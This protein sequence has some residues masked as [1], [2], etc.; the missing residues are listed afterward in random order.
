M[1]NYLK[2]IGPGTLVAAAF[3]GPGTVTVCT[4]AG[5]KFGY[6]LLWVMVFSIFATIVLQ[7]M[8]SR[9]GIISQKNI[10]SIVKQQI[11][12]KYIKTAAI[13][14]IFS[15][16][17]IGNA[18]YEAGNLSGASLGLEAILGPN[19]TLPYPFLTG[20]VAF[21]FLYIGSYKVLEKCMIGLVILMSL[22]FIIA[23]V[24]IQPSLS[25]IFQNIFVPQIPQG[26]LL[27]II[28]LV[29]TTIVPYNLFLHSSL[30]KEKWGKSSDLKSSRI[31]T[32][33]SIF[34]GGLI[35]ISIIIVSAGSGLSDINNALD[36]VI[37]LEPIFGRWAKY[38]IG[39]GLF[40]AGITSSITAPLA[41]SYVAQGCFGWEYGIRNW[42]FK[43]VWM[44][45]IFIG[46][47][48]SSLDIRPIDLIQFA[49]VANGLLLPV[50]AIFLWWAVNKKAILGNNKN[51]LIQN[52]VTGLIIIL[53]IIL[54]L[55]TILNILTS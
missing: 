4:L 7:E 29:G 25:Q 22:S 2:N 40:A 43:S 18:A 55:N 15:A 8:A 9:I 52:M 10:P 35:S 36:M 31:D 46:L 26:G 20:I 53:T 44:F 45:I 27:M 13:I 6:S 34:L 3:I 32:V 38:L 49:Q 30:V 28:S 37:G 42:K 24:L 16:I 41:A 11:K 21:S 12:N 23:A 1:K 50:I 19:P 33:I 17:V 5:A 51:T 48:F 47:L 39:I 14:L 54:G